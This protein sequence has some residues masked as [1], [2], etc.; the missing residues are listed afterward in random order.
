M[1]DKPI[2]GYVID[3]VKMPRRCGIE[4]TASVCILRTENDTIR[5]IL[6]CFQKE[7]K[8]GQK[9]I[10]TQV[11]EPD[12]DVGVPMD[13]EFFQNTSKNGKPIWRINKYDALISKTVFGHVIKS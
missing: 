10:I 12:T 5:V 1:L 6:Q 8:K 9:V 3:Y 11:K 13:S 4:W 2:Q 7:L